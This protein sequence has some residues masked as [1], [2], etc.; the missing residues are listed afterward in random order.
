MIKERNIAVSIILSIVTCG[1]YYFYWIAA[2]SNESSIYLGEEP[3]GGLEVL[4]TL[5]TCNIYGIYWG[6]KMGQK[7]Y[8]VQAR[9]S[10]TPSDDSMLYLLLNLFQFPIVSL[11]IMQSKLNAVASRNPQ[12]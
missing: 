9:T 3:S 5:L 1:I 2:L 4:F 8:D 7:L 12:F 6:Y 11:A 10:N